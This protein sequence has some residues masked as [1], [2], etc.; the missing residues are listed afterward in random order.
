MIPNNG[1]QMAFFTL[2]SVCNK[3]S[4]PLNLSSVVILDLDQILRQLK[5]QKLISLL[6][7]PT[8]KVAHIFSNCVFIKR[9][10][11]I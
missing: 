3:T 8:G 11:R 5:V 2:V 4:R 9:H 1:W 10:E 7:T 6:D